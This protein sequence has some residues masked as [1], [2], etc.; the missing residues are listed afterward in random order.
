MPDLPNWSWHEYGMRVGFWRLLEVLKRYGIRATAATNSAVCDHHPEVI[1]AML[2][3]GWE[4]MGHNET[5][6]L[7]LNEMSPE[8]E[9]KS[10]PVSAEVVKVTAPLVSS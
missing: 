10:Q 8:K 7:R 2:E 5:N 4:L 9:R 3:H 1:D 6:A